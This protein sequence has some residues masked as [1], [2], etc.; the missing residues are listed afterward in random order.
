M[1]HK[2]ANLHNCKYLIKSLSKRNKANPFIMNKLL[3]YLQS[4]LYMV[5]MDDVPNTNFAET[6]ILHEFLID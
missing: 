2:N 5:Q 1:E 3:I 4:N 6:V